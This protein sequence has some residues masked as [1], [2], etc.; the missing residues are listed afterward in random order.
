MTISKVVTGIVAI[1]LFGAAL[2]QE[3]RRVKV[4]V[5]TEDGAHDPVHVQI[6]SDDLGFNLHDMQEGENQAIVDEQGRTILVTREADGFTFNVDGKT[7]NMPMLHEEHGAMVM[8]HGEHDKNVEVEVIHEVSDMDDV[9]EGHYE[10][11]VVKVVKEI[12]VVSDEA[13]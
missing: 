2:A 12:E 10:V 11:K 6:H 13:Q 9:H 8:M 1:G 3:E 4:E 7:I 5:I